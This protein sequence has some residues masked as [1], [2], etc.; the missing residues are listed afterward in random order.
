MKKY[1]HETEIETSQLRLRGTAEVK[2]EPVEVEIDEPLFLDDSLESWGYGG[3]E[4]AVED[5]EV[6]EASVVVLGVVCETKHKS[7]VEKHEALVKKNKALDKRYKTLR[8]KM[9]KLKEDIA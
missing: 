8:D 4:S 1:E 2:F 5:K 6:T 7:L 9:K 3:V